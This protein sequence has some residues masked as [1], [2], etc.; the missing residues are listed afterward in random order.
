MA[1]VGGHLLLF[2]ISSAK[3]GALPFYDLYFK[4]LTLTNARA[5]K[6]EDFPAMIDLLERGAVQLEP[7]VTHRMSLGEL[8]AALGMVEDGSDGRLKIILDHT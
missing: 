6:A 1:R 2:G 3:E 8:E 5:A 4:E 7:L